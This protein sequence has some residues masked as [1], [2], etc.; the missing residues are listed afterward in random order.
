VLKLLQIVLVFEVDRDEDGDEVEAGFLDRIFIGPQY[1]SIH[2]CGIADH[3][4]VDRPL[5]LVVISFM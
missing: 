4:S 1:M 5:P 3:A 2:S